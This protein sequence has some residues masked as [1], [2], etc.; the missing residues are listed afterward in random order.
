MRA[1]L[2]S[3]AVPRE[4]REL[5]GFPAAGTWACG[6]GRGYAGGAHGHARGGG[7]HERAGGPGRVGPGGDIWATFTLQRKALLLSCS[8]GG[9]HSSQLCRLP[10]SDP[11]KGHGKDLQ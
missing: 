2:C 10:C 7:R 8:S 11:G 4:G 6:R 5:P 1:G 3:T 9:P